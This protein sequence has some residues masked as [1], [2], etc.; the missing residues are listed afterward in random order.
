MASTLKNARHLEFLR[1]IVTSSLDIL[2]SDLI[3]TVEGVW[4]QPD[5]SVQAGV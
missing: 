5:V 4:Q 3:H 2:T 1:F